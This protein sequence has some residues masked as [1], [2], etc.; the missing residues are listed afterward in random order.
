[1]AEQ[2]IYF[3]NRTIRRGRFIRDPWAPQAV[4]PLVVALEISAI[5]KPASSSRRVHT[6]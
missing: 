5:R 2:C 1:M 6:G 4:H 3:N